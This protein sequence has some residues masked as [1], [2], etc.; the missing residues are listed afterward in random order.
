MH[1]S[2]RVQKLNQRSSSVS[3]IVCSTHQFGREKNKQWPHLLAFALHDIA[4][5]LI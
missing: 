4:R 3:A 2:G 5:N 1:Q